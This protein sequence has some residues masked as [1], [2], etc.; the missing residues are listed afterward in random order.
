MHVGP[1]L[2]DFPFFSQGGFTLCPCHFHSHDAPM[3]IRRINKTTIKAKPPPI[4]YPVP[5]DIMFPPSFC[6]SQAAPTIINKMNNTT[7]NAKPP[8]YPYP[9]PMRTPSFHVANISYSITSAGE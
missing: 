4:P 7:I 8:P 2:A 1:G 3:I 9:A 6:Y 5:P